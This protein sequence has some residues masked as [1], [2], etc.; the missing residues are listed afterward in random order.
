[1]ISKRIFMCVF[2]FFLSLSL[3]GCNEK[4]KGFVGHWYEVTDRKSPTDIKITY[5]DG[6]FHID[7]HK[8]YIGF[9][10][11][12]Y[13]INKREAKAESDDVISGKLFTM[14]LEDGKLYYNNSEYVKK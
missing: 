13:S 11:D 7:E 9:T 3:L 5:K 4:G 12:E 1:M 2:C 14:R 6:I 8:A 10:G